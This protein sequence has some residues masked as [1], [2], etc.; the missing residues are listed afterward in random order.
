MKKTFIFTLTPEIEEFIMSL[1][2]IELSKFIEI[3][4]LTR[5]LPENQYECYEFWPADGLEFE[6]QVI[7][8]N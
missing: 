5:S 8:L 7:C 2:D 4:I 1:N 6:D 3:L